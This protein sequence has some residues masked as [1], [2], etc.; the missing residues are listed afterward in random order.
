[1]SQTT[2]AYTGTNTTFG[3]L[4]A[5]LNQ[6]T[7]ALRSSFTGTAF[8]PDPIV[9][10]LCWRSDRG[11]LIDGV[12]SGRLYIFMGNVTKGDAGWLTNE[13]TSELA[14]ELIA[15]RGS[16]S[17]LDKRLDIALNEDGSL[18]GDPDT[19]DEWALLGVT[20]TYISSV[21]FKTDSDA[22]EVFKD[23][24]RVKVNLGTGPFYTEVV[25]SAYDGGQDETTVTV[26]LAQID[27]TLVSVGHSVVAPYDGGSGGSL[28]VYT[29]AESDI[30]HRYV[31]MKVKAAEALV[32]IDVVKGSSYNSGEDAIEV[33][34]T[35][36]QTDVAVGVSRTSLALG[37]FGDVVTRGII[38]G[39]D[40]SAW[41][42][43]TI[44]YS[45]GSGG[46]TTVKPAGTYQAIAFVIKNH[47]VTGALMVNIAEPVMSFVKPVNILEVSKLTDATGA[48]NDYFAL[49]VDANG[50]MVV[51]G[52][53]GED[54]GGPSSGAACVFTDN[55][56][57]I[58]KLKAPSPTN[59]AEFGSAVAVDKYKVV[60]GAPFVNDNEPK[61][62]RAYIFN[63][64]GSLVA[65]LTPTAPDSQ[66]YFGNSTAICNDRIL[67]GAY[68]RNS[69]T[70]EVYIFTSSGAYITKFQG[71]S[72][73]TDDNF[74]ISLGINSS[75]IV[76]GASGEDTSATDAGS[77]YVYDLDGVFLFA[78]QAPTPRANG[79]FGHSVSV[80]ESHI[81]ISEY[82]EAD[83]TGEVHLFD[84]G[85]NWITSLT[86]ESPG[87]QYQFGRS[88][89]ISGN[90]LAVGSFSSL[91]VLYHGKV[92]VFDL[93]GNL[94]QSWQASDSEAENFYGQSVSVSGDS[95][96]VG[97]PGVDKAYLYAGVSANLMD[98]LKASVG[99]D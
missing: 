53:P 41:P 35:V 79:N 90:K 40:T 36:S 9:G 86:A 92:W 16:L 23:T 78:L 57:L 2:W 72:P 69:R 54:T 30:L 25:S 45:V 49:A 34:K 13:E 38:E 55:G 46:F 58:T 59:D 5:K 73:A 83:V 28:S 76:I 85:G 63:M 74:G 44:L 66:L 77:A 99:A 75:I 80:S 48:P 22:T 14:S 20:F 60:V 94:V 17:T 64:D 29:R 96:V 11:P 67:I 82:S 10:Q 47:A 8:P 19:G 6:N 87:D 3:E 71:P 39:V 97:S 70:G 89:S 1:M 27:A 68:G 21:S 12:I 32:K 4:A 50:G 61:E 24:R 93:E 43:G 26:A 81:L 98:C 95:L 37:D 65:E 88:V 7:E 84:L 15:A 51:V 91:D 31:P 33:L 56:T 62:G 42:F 52:S 18:K